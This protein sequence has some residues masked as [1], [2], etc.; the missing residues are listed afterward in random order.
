M[1]LIHVHLGNLAVYAE[2][3]TIK[4]SAPTLAVVNPD[5]EAVLTVTDYQ[6]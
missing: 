6:K 3:S 4:F 1:I 5:T 2:L